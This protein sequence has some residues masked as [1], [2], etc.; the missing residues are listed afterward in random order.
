MAIAN[1]KLE[2][3]VSSLPNAGMGLFTKVDFK[4]GDIITEY[5]GK[6][7]TWKKVE[8]DVD[9]GYIYYMNDDCV[10]DARNSIKTFGRYANDAAGLQKVKGHTNNSIYVE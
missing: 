3:K 2:V 8:D 4:K 6:L 5:K 9:N 1:R 7:C 10:I